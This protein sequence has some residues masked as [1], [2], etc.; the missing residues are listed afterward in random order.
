MKP[1]RTFSADVGQTSV[2][3][4]GPDAIER[5]F[6]NINKMF[7]PSAVHADGSQ[8]GIG[9]ENLN[10][11]FGS[12]VELP[13]IDGLPDPDDPGQ[14]AGNISDQI[15]ALYNLITGNDLLVVH[16]AG[17]ETITGAKTFN[18]APVVP[19]P[20]ASTQAASKGYVDEQIGALPDNVPIIGDD[21]KINPVLLPDDII[22]GG[23]SGYSNILDA[24][25]LNTSYKI[26]NYLKSDTS[27]VNYIKIYNE[28]F[29]FIAAKTDGSETVQ[30]RDRNNELV[31]WADAEHTDV[32]LL[33][34][35]RPVLTYVYTELIKNSFSFVV[36]AA[37]GYYVPKITL[38]A[39]VTSPTNP[40]PTTWGKGYIYKGPTGL[41]IE[42]ISTTGL[43]RIIKLTD[44]GI[45][46]S[47][48][49]AIKF[50]ETVQITGLPRIWVQPDAP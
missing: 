10:F 1:Q 43:S 45:D 24:D 21:G 31:Y 46:L 37:T 25:R 36:D 49:D 44:E 2:D 17:A 50:S 39:G 47:E 13:P 28:R 3:E 40:V 27:D 32:T 23:G 14:P 29:D 12:D 5:D 15:L 42:Y 6:D 26:S 9:K 34:T 11:S 22:S 18:A 4:R 41:Y 7:D 48:F 35:D 33:D 8:G 38:G 16:K 19:T 20:T 30:V